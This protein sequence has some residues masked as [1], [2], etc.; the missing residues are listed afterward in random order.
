MIPA[1][2]RVVTV[3]GA[4]IAGICLIRLSRIRQAGMRPAV[5]LTT[6]NA[7]HRFA[8]ALD[9]PAGLR[10]C[11]FIPRRDTDSRLTALVGG[12][13]FPGWHHLASFAETETSGHFEI[14]MTSHD[15]ECRVEIAARIA[16]RV[17][18]GSVFGSLDEASRFF[19]SAPIGYSARPGSAVLDAVQLDCHGWQL[20]SLTIDRAIS[21][22]FEDLDSFPPGSVEPD[23]AFL[24]RRIETI[25]S[26]LS[27]LP[28]ARISPRR[29]PAI[30]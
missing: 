22:Y 13:L 29:I 25:W 16:D 15:R 23:S 21:T 17:M 26:A 1:P 7:A 6:E 3:G 8:V 19:G 18:P 2:F 27:P 10:Q 14:S 5:G 12:R 30:S 4:V 24:M 9:T 11:V 20:V 28:A